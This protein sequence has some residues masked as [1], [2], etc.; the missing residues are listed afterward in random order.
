MP[1][2]VRAP[3]TPERT[4]RSA[5]PAFGGCNGQLDGTAVASRCTGSRSWTARN[6]RCARSLDQRTVGQEV[7]NVA[8][9]DAAISV[10]ETARPRRAGVNWGGVRGDSRIGKRALADGQFGAHGARPVRLVVGGVTTASTAEKRRDRGEESEM[11]R[12]H[13]LGRI[14]IRRSPANAGVHPSSWQ[15]AAHAGECRI[16]VV[17]RGRGT[18]L[19]ARKT[20]GRRVQR[21][22]IQVLGLSVILG[23]ETAVV[24]AERNAVDLG[25]SPAAR[26]ASAR[27]SPEDGSAGTTSNVLPAAPPSSQLTS[28]RAQR[29]PR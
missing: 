18:N 19:H 7:P 12:A 28:P 21:P 1:Q 16:R 4:V 8:V 9:A 13:C 15:G 27:P 5:G 25:A 6:R 24:A 26:T 11:L 29:R 2:T 14:T 10:R 23:T 20:G 3:A 17:A 22:V